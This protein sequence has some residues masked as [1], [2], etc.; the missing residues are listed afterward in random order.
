MRWSGGT[1]ALAAVLVAAPGA[2]AQTRS[3]TYVPIGTLG[4]SY[5]TGS[6]G[7][8]V[9]EAG[10]VTGWGVTNNPGHTRA[11][12]WQDGRIA[13]LGAGLSQGTSAASAINDAG[14]IVGGTDVDRYQ[15]SHAFV[16]RD[17]K[18][19]VLG[20][21]Y[22]SGSHAF[23]EAV[24][25]A[26][27]IVGTR[28]TGGSAPKR[29]FLWRD[30]RFIDL[31]S[32]GGVGGP[33][34]IETSAEDINDR[35]QIVGAS[36]PTKGYPVHAYLWEDGRMRDLGVLG[37]DSEA[38]QAFAIN[39]E[40]QIVGNSFAHNRQTEPF[41]WEDGI[42]TQLE[43]LGGDGATPNDI[44]DAG[45]IV[46]ASKP[47]GSYA[48]HA[49]LWS[50]GQVHD[51]NDLVANLPAN[52]SLGTA[53]AIN[54]SGV[55]VGRSCLYSCD[56][57]VTTLDHGYVL[58]PAGQPVPTPKPTLLD[59]SSNARPLTV[60]G[61]PPTA[62]K[63]RW[64][65]G[66]RF[67]SGGRLETPGFA[68]PY[69]H[70][71]NAWVQPEGHPA[72]RQMIVGQTGVTS[73]FYD[74]AQRSYGFTVVDA[75]GQPATFTTPSG[76]A[77]GA[78]FR[79]VLGGITKSGQLAVSIDGRVYCG[80]PH[81][82]SIAN[83]SGTPITVGAATDGSQPFHGVIEGALVAPGETGTNH[84]RLPWWEHVGSSVSVYFF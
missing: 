60:A 64:G 45:D 8:D 41:L 77:A 3:Y 1:V 27:E 29:G 65:D 71:L 47:T 42:M 25:N 31:G 24:N 30:G 10:Q 38:T 78:G 80:A 67:G 6:A 48:L 72:S 33:Y 50:D 37:D 76:S 81:V 28:S 57:G 26:G 20:T 9:N 54:E 36:V 35:G 51:L 44:N 2:H 14:D 13:S 11:I 5:A 62:A 58:I 17:N 61:P 46:G 56:A 68:I 53:E 12:R 43:S 74:G 52:V 22:G 73:L 16:F 7:F 82:G 34:N 32:L 21:G 55:I 15:P 84:F 39:N 63:G 18:L 66:L 40:G 79:Y 4:T 23:A 49:T 59:T 70:G 83:G 19:T 75:G 69:K